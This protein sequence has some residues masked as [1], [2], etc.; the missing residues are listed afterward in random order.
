M[1]SL[2]QRMTEDMQVRNLA[3]NTQT[4]ESVPVTPTFRSPIGHREQALNVRPRHASRDP[5]FARNVNDRDSIDQWPRDIA[6]NVEKLQKAAQSRHCL[7]ARLSQNLSVF[8]TQPA[9]CLAGTRF[10]Y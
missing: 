4:W 9:A 1:T 10:P 2:R 6:V 3:L 8:F 5:I 7:L